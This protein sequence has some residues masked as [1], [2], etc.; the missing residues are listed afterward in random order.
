MGAVGDAVS[1]HSPRRSF[2]SF[3][4]LRGKV[5]MGAVRAGEKKTFSRHLRRNMTDAELH[6]WRQLRERQVLGCKFRRQHPVGPYVADF[7]SIDAMLVI[8]VDGGQHAESAADIRRTRFIEASGYRV[9][10]FWNNDVLT[11]I[12]G[13]MLVIHAALVE[14]RPHPDLPP[15]AGEGDK[16]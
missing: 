2:N 5:G 8:E 3:P 14:T 15:P 11:N 16:R 9:L 13:V 7:A 6:I 10:R 4:R 12:E 1:T